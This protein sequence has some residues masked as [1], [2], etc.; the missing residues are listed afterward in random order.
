MDMDARRQTNESLRNQENVA[1]MAPSPDRID[2]RST[3]SSKRMVDM[4]LDSRRRQME[5]E[6]SEDVH[7]PDGAFL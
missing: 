3:M 5:G 4:F 1:G 7:A 6:V 2:P